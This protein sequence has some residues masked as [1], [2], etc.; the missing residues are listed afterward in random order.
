[1]KNIFFDLDT[2]ALLSKDGG[3]RPFLDIIL[4]YCYCN[5][6]AISLMVSPN[7]MERAQQFFDAYKS[8]DNPYVD[9]CVILNK[10]GGIPTY[11]DLVISCDGEYLNKYPGLL[12]PPYDPDRSNR[13]AE[14]AFAGTLIESIKNRVVL[15]RHAPEKHVAPEPETPKD[16]SGDDFSSW[17]YT[18]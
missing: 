6:I 4:E 3:A 8:E 18:V 16:N 7:K 17:A 14:L 13:F 9:A 2:T 11:P 10:G 15:N 5:K 1:M 12:V